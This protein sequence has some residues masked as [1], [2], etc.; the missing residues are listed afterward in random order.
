MSN[1]YAPDSRQSVDLK[2]KLRKALEKNVAP[3]DDGKGLDFG[4]DV[5]VD[6]KL[7]LN[8]LSDIVGPSGS[9]LFTD[10]T[11]ENVSAEVDSFLSDC[12]AHRYE[13]C[14]LGFTSGASTAPILDCV[15]FGKTSNFNGAYAYANVNNNSETYVLTIP[16]ITCPA[17]SSFANAFNGI[18]VKGKLVFSNAFEPGNCIEIFL[19]TALSEI[20]GGG[21]RPGNMSY[22][23]FANSSL[24]KISN[25]DF[26]RTYN[27]GVAF[28]LDSALA[29]IDC[30]G[31]RVS[32][33]VSETAL[34][35]DAIVT[36]INS[37]DTVT[38]PETL[39][40]GDEKLA[41]LSDEEKLGATNKG[42]TL[43]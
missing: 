23:F 4:Q 30:T 43:A 31:W 26:S 10:E 33:D 41:L 16:V 28:S 19:G 36:L 27:L 14:T 38:S 25:F 12:M 13:G 5:G 37:L 34:G 39:T 22:G 9:P 1:E 6:G 18:R 2:W 24:R 17:D 20:D 7:H 29:E 11:Q 8:E 40:L 42:W 35:H 32:F 21:M 3:R 15:K